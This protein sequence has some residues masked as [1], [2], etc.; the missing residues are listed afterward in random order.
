MENDLRNQKFGALTALFKAGKTEANKAIWK[1]LCDCGNYTKAVAGHLKSGA[2]VSCGCR[3]LNKI[4]YWLK[5]EDVCTKGVIKQYQG[6]AK[7]RNL[8]FNLSYEQFKV[9]LFENCHYCNKKPSNKFNTFR[10]TYNQT[11]DKYCYYNGIDRINNTKGYFMENCVSC[12]K[13]C[14]IMKMALGK[15]K[16]L[17]HI[18]RIYNFSIK[19]LAKRRKI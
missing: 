1:C 14:N 2:R 9:L 8:E 13:T 4:Q 16:F 12:C 7:R 19:K 11:Y 5:I 18:K 15:D 10:N 6:E 3:K 17:S